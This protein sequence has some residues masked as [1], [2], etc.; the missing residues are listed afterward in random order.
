MEQIIMKYLFFDESKSGRKACESTD[1]RCDAVLWVAFCVIVCCVLRVSRESQWSFRFCESIGSSIMSSCLMHNATEGNGKLERSTYRRVSSL[2]HH[3]RST[4]DADRML[5]P[6][7]SEPMHSGSSFFSRTQTQWRA[8]NLIRSE[9]K[10]LIFPII[11]YP[12]T[13]AREHRPTVPS[14]SG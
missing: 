2:R 8:T 9:I 5:T 11:V 6:D 3:S 1:R 10:P 4:M 12:K 14:F 7:P 13:L